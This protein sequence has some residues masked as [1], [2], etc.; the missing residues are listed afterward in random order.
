MAALTHDNHFSRSWP[1][2]PTGLDSSSR[3]VGCHASYVHAIVGGRPIVGPLF[4][5]VRHRPNAR[6]IGR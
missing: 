4:T 3:E 2:L 1:S 6:D 5:P